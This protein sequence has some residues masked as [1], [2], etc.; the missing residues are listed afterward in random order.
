MYSSIAPLIL[1]ASSCLLIFNTTPLVESS[2]VRD[3]HKRSFASLGCLGVYNKA[4]F[5]RLS[6]VCEDCYQM[7]RDDDLH[8]LCRSNCFNNEYFKKCLEALLLS[9]EKEKFDEM[10]MD[11]YGKK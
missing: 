1:L 5:A 10:V 2:N 11:L 8:G 4:T 6:R 3:L 7:Y 9:H